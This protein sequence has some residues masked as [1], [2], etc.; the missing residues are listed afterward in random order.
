[1]TAAVE[2]TAAPP[3]RS[4]GG[5]T[6]FGRVLYAVLWV[7]CR[8]LGVA[9]FGIRVRFAEKLPGHGGLLVL[10]SHQSHLDPLLLGLATDRRLS[11]LARSS[12]YRFKPFGF[13]ITALDAVP[14]DR[15]S[16]AVAGM[17]AV[18]ERLRRGA[19]VIVFPEGTRTADGRLGEIKGGLS[20]IARRAGVPI[21]P[22]A[23]V[24]AYECWPRTRRFPRPGRIRLEFGRIMSP[25]EIAA[26]DDAALTAEVATR[27]R[28]LDAVAR[29]ARCHSPSPSGRGPVLISPSPSGR[30]PV[31]IS[32][33]PSGRGPG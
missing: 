27:L 1:M 33:S 15:E 32:P 8:T 24:G 26:L 29:A 3:G 23:I 13:V 11:S 22:V 18:I 5:H 6:R 20:V 17:R 19:A 25:G 4:G 9:L 14:V 30:G 7:L 12:L 10:S 16:S 28:H 21:V 2:S 31:L